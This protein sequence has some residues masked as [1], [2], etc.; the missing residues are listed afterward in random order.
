[1]VA[2]LCG[3]RFVMGPVRLEILLFI[4]A[5]Y[6]AWAGRTK[7]EED[8]TE[9]LPSKCEGTEMEQFLFASPYPTSYLSNSRLNQMN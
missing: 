2:F 9:R 7:E 8:D 3:L 5:V 1:M 6:G 4:L